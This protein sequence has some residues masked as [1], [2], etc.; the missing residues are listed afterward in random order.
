ML[1][2]NFLSLKLSSIALMLLAGAVGL[3]VFLVRS[4]KGG[5]GK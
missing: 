1:A 4:R 2:V 3:A 5:A